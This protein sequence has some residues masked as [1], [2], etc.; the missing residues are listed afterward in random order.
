MP[1]SL[2]V[3]LKQ[4]RFAMFTAAKRPWIKRLG[5]A[6]FAAVAVGMVALSPAPAQAQAYCGPY[7]GGYYG[8]PSYYHPYYSPRRVAYRGCG[9]G[10]HWVPP[11]SNPWGRW[12]PG[13]CR[14]NY[15]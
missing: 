3:R 7:G 2:G 1:E 11:H 12:V 4:M 8:A 6:A 9:W 10:S 14:P 13:S 5:L 15:Y